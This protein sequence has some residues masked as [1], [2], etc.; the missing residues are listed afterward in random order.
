MLG[1]DTY[2]EGSWMYEAEKLKTSIMRTLVLSILV[3]AVGAVSLQAQS[4]NEVV[5]R[6]QRKADEKAVV[7]EL[8]RLAHTFWTPKL[9]EYRRFI[10][11]S[12]AE[13]DLTQLSNLR[14]RFEFFM[15]QARQMRQ[16]QRA[17]YEAVRET[18]EDVCGQESAEY[19]ATEDG[20]GVGIVSGPCIHEESYGVASADTAAAHVDGAVDVPPKDTSMTVDVDV[21]APADEAPTATAPM[22]EGVESAA[23]TDVASIQEG[24]IEI[25]AEDYSPPESEERMIFMATTSLAARYG[26]MSDMLRR[27]VSED[28]VDFL[29]QV[30]TLIEKLSKQY[31]SLQKL[32]TEE[33][34]REMRDVAKRREV[35]DELLTH[36]WR[37]IRPLVMLYNGQGLL[38]M[39]VSFGL[40]EFEGVDLSVASAEDEAAPQ[41]RTALTQN[42]PNPA[43]AFT[44]ISYHL[45]EPSA[46]TRLKVISTSGQE[47]ADIDLGSLASGDHQTTV[48]VSSYAPGAYVYRLSAQSSMGEEVY[49]K[50]MQ[51]VR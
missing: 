39:L 35:V 24:E 26:A 14:L 25:K 27:K 43:T 46:T 31:P 13:S 21:P 47:M 36:G 17:R 20:E 32:Q 15:E 3:A 37:E 40:D 9:N 7:K 19:E 6:E 22:E 38:P 51:V 50:F 12:L 5:T 4:S 49:S 30:V 18:D 23:G 2:S 48:D 34:F 10:D 16:A 42:S 41:G 28:M 29:D 8:I 45:A 1:G 33:E 44:V 11:R